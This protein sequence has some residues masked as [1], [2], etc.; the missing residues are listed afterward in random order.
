MSSITTQVNRV[1][2]L[3]PDGAVV[4]VASPSHDQDSVR[5]FQFY[6]LRVSDN[7]AFPFLPRPFSVYDSRP[8]ELD[9]L[10]KEVG[11]GTAVLA[12][13]QPGE[14]I[15]IAGP[16]GN[17]VAA[18]PSGCRVVGVAG[19]VGI[20]PFLL[21]FKSS[22]IPKGSNPLLIYGAKTRDLL[23]DLDLF[24]G[25]PIEVRTCTEDGSHGVKGRV[26]TLLAD[27]LA[28]AGGESAQVLCCGPDP[29]MEAVAACCRSRDVTCLVSL[30]NFM[31]CGYGVCNACAVKVEDERY[32]DGFRYDRSCMEGPVFDA[33]TIEMEG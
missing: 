7:P 19:G 15:S 11:A 21:L 28:E 24:T 22:L 1:R 5:P 6:M 29:M 16:L 33:S 25:L 9:F 2:S 26:D 18:T 3:P 27:A 4:T 13:L 30:E 12:H 8:G 32:Q 17:G 20:A 14:P 23:W 10:V 31:A